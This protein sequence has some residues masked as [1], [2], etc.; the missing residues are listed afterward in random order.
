[1]YRKPTSPRVEINTRDRV[2]I[3]RIRR[4]GMKVIEEE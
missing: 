2:R 1:M 4:K 3:M